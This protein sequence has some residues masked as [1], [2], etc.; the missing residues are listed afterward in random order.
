[1]SEADVEKIIQ[2]PKNEWT[3]TPKKIL[4]YLDHMNRA[5]L[6]SAKASDWKDIFFPLVHGASG[7]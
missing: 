3:T 7:S 4:V 1:M 6:V 2:A 5:G